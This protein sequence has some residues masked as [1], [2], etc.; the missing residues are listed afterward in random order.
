M[1]P[2]IEG[3]FSSII[4]LNPSDIDPFVDLRESPPPG[5]DSFIVC[6][7][8]GEVKTVLWAPGPSWVI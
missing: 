2:S 3:F 6:S 1:T 4:I 7:V 5:S 8:F